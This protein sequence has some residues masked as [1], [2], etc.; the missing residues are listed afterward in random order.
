MALNI[1]V[2]IDGYIKLRRAKEELS[3]KHKLEMAPIMS[4]MIK[5]EAFLMNELNKA[6]VDSLS[7]KGIGT[8]FKQ[9][10]TSITSEDWPATLDWIK[11]NNAWEMLERRVSKAAAQE[12]IEANGDIPPGLKVAMDVVVRIRKG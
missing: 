9:T 10:T 8:A 6:G 7:A 1:A 2:V 3:E 11:E 5:L 4:N 12:Y